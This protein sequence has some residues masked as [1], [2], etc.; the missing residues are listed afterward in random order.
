M[1]GV[2]VVLI[3]EQ[4]QWV[5][6]EAVG[7]RRIWRGNFLQK[8]P[9]IA[10]ARAANLG[11]RI[12]PCRVPQLLLEWACPARAGPGRE[13]PVVSSQ[14]LTAKKR[15]LQTEGSGRR[16]RMSRSSLRGRLKA[17]ALVLP[18][19]LNSPATLSNQGGWIGFETKST[20]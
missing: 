6:G 12:S 19:V 2:S 18:R 10:G 20:I 15:R 8:Y 3:G 5:G 9:L 1:D 13:N 14:A 17:P 7:Q 11:S 4:W 16:W